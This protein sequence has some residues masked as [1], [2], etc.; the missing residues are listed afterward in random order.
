MQLQLVA[1]FVDV[2]A[3]CELI[4]FRRLTGEDRVNDLDAVSNLRVRFARQLQPSG[5]T[6]TRIRVDELSTLRNSE[7]VWRRSCMGVGVKGDTHAHYP[8]RSADITSVQ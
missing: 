1:E 2:T 8:V 7:Q 4:N 3:V 6:S 5:T